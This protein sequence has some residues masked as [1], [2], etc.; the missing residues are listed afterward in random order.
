[1]LTYREGW[2]PQNLEYR[3]WGDDQVVEAARLVR[4]LHDATAGS[5]LSAD[6]EVVCHGDL[7]PCNVV[8]VDR[9]PRYLIDF[10]SARPGTR[11]E[12]L[13]YMAWMWLVGVEDP[14]ESPPLDARLARMRLLLD[15]YGLGHR[16][17]FAEAILERQRA[18]RAAM[19][20]RGSNPWWVDA[21]IRFVEDHAARIT[22]AAE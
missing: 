10:D 22:A 4:A 20:G 7:S 5:P 1:M 16:A 8:F 17:R 3:S 15:A 11:R 19:V 2:V 21:E 13:A 14:A 18:V 12:D 6:A 9:I